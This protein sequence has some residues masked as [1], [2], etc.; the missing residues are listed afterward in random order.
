MGEINLNQKNPTYSIITDGK[1]EGKVIR[2]YKMSI[3]IFHQNKWQYLN[4]LERGME[5]GYDSRPITESEAESIVGKKLHSGEEEFM[6]SAE[7]IIP[8]EE[9]I[10]RAREYVENL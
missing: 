10:K 2:N 8:S 1:Y 6:K 7:K 9:D 5:D 3:E 4:M